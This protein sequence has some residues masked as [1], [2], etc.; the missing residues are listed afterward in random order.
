MKLPQACRLIAI[1]IFLLSSFSCTQ[2]KHV[3]EEFNAE[4]YR[5]T[6][7]LA[8]PDGWNIERFSIPIDFAPTINYQ[9]VEDIRFTPGWADAASDSYWTYAFLWYLEGKQENNPEIIEKNLAAYY[10]G[11]IGRNIDKRN[12]PKDKISDVVVKI[13]EASTDD[14]DLQTYSGTINMLDYMA[15]KPMTL[16]CVVHIKLCPDQPDNT[17]VFYEISPRPL[18]D[19]VWKELSNLWTTFECSRTN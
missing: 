3:A 16:N 10:N 15:Q 2:K 17:F 18:N 19:N 12:I 6:Y 7:S 8:T 1:T 4:L 9:G 11:L 5:P 14:G 13:N